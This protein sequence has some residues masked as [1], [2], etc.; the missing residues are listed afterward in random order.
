MAEITTKAQK[1][2]EHMLLEA[3]MASVGTVGGGVNP[4]SSPEPGLIFGLTIGLRG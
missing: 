1:S 4:H 3:N 2:A